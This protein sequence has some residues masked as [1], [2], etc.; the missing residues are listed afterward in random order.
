[1]VDRHGENNP[2]Y[3]HGCAH[4]RIYSVYYNMIDRCHNPNYYNYHNYGARGITVCK[5]WRENKKAFFEWAFDNGYEIGLSLDRIDNDK[6]YSPEN[7]RWVTPKFQSNHKT[8]NVFYTFNGR[9][10]TSKQWCDEYGI[11]QTTFNDR[12]KRGW[13]LEQ[14]LTISTRGTHR[15]VFD[16]RDREVENVWLVE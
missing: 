5:E 2:M 15:K 10:Q 14:A 9:T 13:S 3:K 16:C 12:L 11:S 4:T 6:G 1:M 8:N 7:C